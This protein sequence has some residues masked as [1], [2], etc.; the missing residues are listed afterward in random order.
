MNYKDVISRIIICPQDNR[1]KSA[2]NFWK[3]ENLL[4]QK[5]YKLFPNDIFWSSISLE[6]TIAKNGRIP[7]FSYFF[8]KDS[9]YWINIL[10]NKW[11]VFNW[12][13]QKVKNYNFKKECT[14]N[15]NFKTK[16]KTLRKFLS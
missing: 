16:K 5:I 4:F 15:L 11:K 6:D 8:D 13:P 14:E 10:K 12:T 9:D 1:T 7:S 2:K 3:K